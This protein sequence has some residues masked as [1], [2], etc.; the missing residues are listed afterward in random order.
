MRYCTNDQLI[1]I[2]TK[3]SD[4]IVNKLIQDD[5]DLE[6]NY[7]G[8]YVFNFLSYGT[9]NVVSGANAFSRTWSSPGP[10]DSTSLNL[11]ALYLI[12]MWLGSYI[13]DQETGEYKVGF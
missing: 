12:R 3:C 13:I 5:N 4:C 11:S 6:D 7:S 8:Y 1:E 9:I 10:G 2:F